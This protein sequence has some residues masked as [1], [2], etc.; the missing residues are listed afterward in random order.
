[1]VVRNIELVDLNN[2]LAATQQSTLLLFLRTKVAV[3]TAKVALKAT[4]GLD[5]DISEFLQAVKEGAVG[6][7]ADRTLDEEAL[8]RVVS[9]EE[10]AGADIQ[11][12]VRASYEA[13][14]RFMDK[15][16]HDRRKSAKEGD[17]YIDFTEKMQRVSDGRGGRVWVR[18]E[19]VR[20]WR[21]SLSTAAPLR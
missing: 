16:K 6:E 19:N 11:R 12:D 2:E 1:M 18:T 4:A 5:V 21:N 15:E 14:K 20:R 17:G 7:V 9:G 10:D 8:S 13:L 3:V